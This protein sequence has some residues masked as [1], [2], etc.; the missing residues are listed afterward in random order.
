MEIALVYVSRR[1][2]T[3]QVARL[4]QNRL[5]PHRV[6]LLDLDENPAPDLTDF[7][8]VILGGPI[9]MGDLPEKLRKFANVST[10]LLLTKKLGLFIC[11]MIP[12]KEKQQ[13]ELERAYP[14]A[15]R[16]HA[17]ALAFMGG[18]FIREKLGFFEKL[19]VRLI[20]RTH[21]SVE[22]IDHDAIRDF[23]ARIVASPG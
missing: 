10:H 7:D 21:K 5:A 17:T 19:V 6:V 15:L 9:Y 20:A 11:G 18:A 2:T 3:E 13:A 1:G 22:R 16:Q 23:C 14:E 4:I 8:I 12:D